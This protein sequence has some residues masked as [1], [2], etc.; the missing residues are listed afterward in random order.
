VGHVLSVLDGESRAQIGNI[1]DRAIAHWP[2]FTQVDLGHEVNRSTDR[3]PQVGLHCNPPRCVLASGARRDET[4]SRHVRRPQYWTGYALASP[5]WQYVL[6]PIIRD[7]TDDFA[8]SSTCAV[9]MPNHS[10]TRS[11][12]LQRYRKNMYPGTRVIHRRL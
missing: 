8:R 3:S 10:C 6:P 2:T 7:R 1:Q 11:P 9:R 12:A 4:A 5:N